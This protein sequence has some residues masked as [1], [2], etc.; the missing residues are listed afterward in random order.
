VTAVSSSPVATTTARAAPPPPPIR[1]LVTRTPSATN[2]KEPATN[3]SPERAS[4]GPSRTA[5]QLQPDT[6][7]LSGAADRSSLRSTR[8]TGSLK[9]SDACAATASAASDSPS[10]HQ[11]CQT[12]LSTTNTATSCTQTDKE[13]TRQRTRT[14][15]ARTQTD[16]VTVITTPTPKTYKR[17]QT[18]RKQP[19]GAPAAAA[20]ASCQ[21]DAEPPSPSPLEAEAAG[22]R[23]LVAALRDALGAAVGERDR[24]YHGAKGALDREREARKIAAADLHEARHQLAQSERDK[25]V[26][27]RHCMELKDDN[28]NLNNQ[29]HNTNVNH[30]SSAQHLFN[31]LQQAIQG[32]MAT[33]EALYK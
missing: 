1:T 12:E 20:S 26:L 7:V 23:G 14:A 27:A 33:R 28:T 10:Q 30:S 15:A 18:S 6:P 22:L 24:I 9:G 19:P 31:Q 3:E 11:H 21:T 2:A 16:A 4:S 8:T 29:L 25:M 5:E 17:T 32:E 13:P